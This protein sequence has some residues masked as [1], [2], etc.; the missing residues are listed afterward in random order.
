M[1]NILHFYQRFEQKKNQSLCHH[2][3]SLHLHQFFV[4]VD[5]EKNNH[6]FQLYVHRPVFFLQAYLQIHLKYLGNNLKIR[7]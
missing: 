1:L 3:P 6:F 5:H 2:L 7:R 4:Q